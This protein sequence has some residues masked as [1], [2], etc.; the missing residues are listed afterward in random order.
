M[1]NRRSFELSL[2]LWFAAGGGCP[3]AAETNALSWLEQ[4]LALSD[5]IDLALQHNST[6]LKGKS[7]LEASYGVVIQTRAIAIPKV[8]SGASYQK[9]QASGVETFPPVPPTILSP[10]P[11][12]RGDQKWSGD[13]RLVQSVYEGGRILSALRTAKL[14]KEQA[15]LQYQT[16]IA[17]TLL[18]V[19]ISYNDVLLG[20]QE[21]VVQQA[22]VDLLTNELTDQK[23]RFEAGTVP[24]FN[25]L[26]AE[27]ELAN[28]RPRLIHARNDYRVAKNNLAVLIGY[29]LPTNLGED[30]PLKLTG[31]L[32]A[33]PLDLELPV[34]IAQALENRTELAS[35]R[36]AL[37]LAKEAVITAQGARLPSVE[38][39]TGYGSHNSIF[40]D[41]LTRDVSGWYAGALM[42]WDIFDGLYTKGKIDE[43]KALR[44]RA[45]YDLEDNTRK[46]ELEVRTSYSN[47]IEAREV[48]E[49][50]KKVQESAE[51]T[52][53]LAT[54]R[55]QAGTGTQLDVLSAQTALT[56][57]RTTQIQ[58]LRD[59]AV[60]RARMER[61]V[62][63]NIMQQK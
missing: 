45:E 20:E 57:A 59:Y 11:Q 18:A 28:A 27:V 10:F 55:S 50:Q 32:E 56:E 37:G 5:C 31:R 58:A 30:I 3:L 15:L 38:V 60:A 52:L 4:P 19:R 14:T 29:N 46:V 41:D 21:I 9:T 36:K 35:L 22:S 54:V 13:I 49:S 62:G 42:N 26:R 43:A 2:V 53:R 7:D 1:K 23:R 39:F 16:V 6:I 44:Q 34:A 48:L 63:Q 51:E 33:E 47:F 8:R 61:A 12:V 40:T 17:D 24:R 25:V